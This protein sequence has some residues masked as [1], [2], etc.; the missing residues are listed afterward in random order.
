VRHNKS[1]GRKPYVNARPN[2][3][4]PLKGVT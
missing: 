3:R 1:I 2:Q 4:E